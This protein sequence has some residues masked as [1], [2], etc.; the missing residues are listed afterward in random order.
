MKESWIETNSMAILPSEVRDARTAERNLRWGSRF[1]YLASLG[2]VAAVKWAIH[3]DWTFGNNRVEYVLLPMAVYVLAICYVIGHHRRLAQ[4][5]PAVRERRGLR[6][7]YQAWLCVFTISLGLSALL[8]A[9]AAVEPRVSAL[10]AG[11]DIAIGLA[12]EPI[13]AKIREA[14]R[15]GETE[16]PPNAGR[17]A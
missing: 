14:E 8:F 17:P 15:R 11:I 5:S 13:F 3:A 1:L 16:A 6:F 10:I 7:L 12:G 2:C 9:L 4:L